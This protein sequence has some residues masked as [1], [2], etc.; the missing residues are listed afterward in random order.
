MANERSLRRRIEAAIADWDT[1]GYPYDNTSAIQI[2]PRGRLPRPV[3]VLLSSE[4]VD[5]ALSS[6]GHTP[7]SFLRDLETVRWWLC[8]RATKE[9]VAQRL[10][11]NSPN[12]PP[13]Q[14]AS[15]AIWSMLRSV[16]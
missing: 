3:E 15:E 5:L 12:Y 16:F 9:E 10:S 4:F 13:L 11:P 1:N 2:P 6:L 7:G 14:A 8:C